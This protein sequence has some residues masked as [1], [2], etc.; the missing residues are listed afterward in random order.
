LQ[1]IVMTPSNVSNNVAKDAAECRLLCVI[2]AG[3]LGAVFKSRSCQDGSTNAADDS[4]ANTGDCLLLRGQCDEGPSSC[5]DL[6]RLFSQYDM[7]G[8]WRLAPPKTSLVD[9][10]QVAEEAASEAPAEDTQCSNWDKIGLGAPVMATMGRCRA[11]CLTD[12]RC[13]GFSFLA[14]PWEASGTGL[15]KLSSGTCVP[16]KD[17]GWRYVSTASAWTLKEAGSGCENWHDILLT[18]TTE[19]SHVACGLRCLRTDGCESFNY[20]P[21]GH[22]NVS[23]VA[24]P[25]TCTLFSG[26]CELSPNKAWNFFQLTDAVGGVDRRELPPLT[27]LIDV[28]ALATGPGYESL[29]FGRCALVGNSDTMLGSGLGKEIHDNDVVI[30][31]NRVPDPEFWKDFGSRTD[32]LFINNMNALNR[33]VD[34]MQGGDNNSKV[35]CESLEICRRAVIIDNGN[36]GCDPDEMADIWGRDHMAVGCQHE[37]STGWSWSLEALGQFRPTTGFQAFLTFL[38]VCRELNLFG[39]AGLGTGDGHKTKDWHNLTGEHAVIQQIADQKW[40]EIRWTRFDDSFR[41]LVQ[42]SAVVRRI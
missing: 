39:F 11:L 12:E 21:D 14:A 35:D 19:L 2:N 30:R 20:K 36:L 17:P 10:A 22:A 18:S 37:N 23:D 38:P 26:P 7:S 6:F 9:D 42:H 15:C 40:D 33:D 16:A 27:N 32:V 13:M 5:F 31:I 4:D 1:D 25:R 28:A 3:C 24:S 29:R 41:W 34:L 8:G